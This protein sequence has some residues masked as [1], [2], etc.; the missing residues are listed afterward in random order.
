[1]NNLLENTTH[2]KII[3]RINSLN[4]NSKRNWGKMNVD[5]ML[6]HCADQIRLALGEKAGTEEAP[7]VNEHIV[8]PV[9]LL[10][11]RIPRWKYKAPADMSQDEGGRGTKPISSENDRRLLIETIHRYYNSPENFKPKP[12]PAYGRLNRKQWGRFMYLHLDYHLRQFS[13]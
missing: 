12:H 8:L 1:L 2:S 5:Q 3:Q 7:W 9:A 10:L 11:P 4:E 6:C 13:C